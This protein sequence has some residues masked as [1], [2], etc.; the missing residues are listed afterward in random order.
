MHIDLKCNK[1][2]IMCSLTLQ[3]LVMHLYEK[4]NLHKLVNDESE[5]FICLMVVI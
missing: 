5:C 1:L 3:V 2:E 4:G